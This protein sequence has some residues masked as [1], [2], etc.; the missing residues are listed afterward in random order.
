LREVNAVILRQQ[1]ELEEQSKH[2]QES[3]TALATSNME[4]DI[5]NEHLYEANQRLEAA[6]QRLEA[7]NHEKD[8]LL[9]IV[10]HDL[11]NPL[12][13]IM[14]SS[15]TLAQAANLPLER[16]MA[17]G[18]RI[19]QS[20]ERM[21]NTITKLLSLNA[22]EQGGKTLET[23]RFNVA[24]LVRDLVAEEF[25]IPGLCASAFRRNAIVRG[26]RLADWIGKRF[27]FQGL[28]FEGSEECK[29]CY[30]MNEAVAPGVEDF[31]KSE[32]RG[33]LRARILS[34]GVLESEQ[35]LRQG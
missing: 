34:D 7:L 35:T 16:I 18:E 31:L 32:C 25:G 2:I 26:V 12:T 1:R 4:L 27:V 20:S 21:L 10:A 22:L 15:S 14:M 24:R 23:R 30:W 17:M 8:E 6:N 33:G 28:E 11:K 3:N 9:G 19:L 29:P 5:K 13:A